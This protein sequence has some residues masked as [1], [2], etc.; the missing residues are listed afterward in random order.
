M[1]PR[2][3]ERWTQEIAKHVDK[4]SKEV[5]GLSQ[6]RASVEYEKQVQVALELMARLHSNSVSYANLILV[7]GYAGF[8]A[9]WSTLENNLP[10]WLH[11]LSGLLIV[12][13]LLFFLT[14]EVVK[15]IWSA[16][17]LRRIEHQMTQ[18]PPGADTMTQ[19]QQALNAYDRRVGRLWVWFLL[20]TIVFGLGGGLALLVGFGWN[21]WS[22]II[23][24]KP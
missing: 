2:Q 9:F 11:A 13:S 12:L 3:H 15:M 19:F 7:A 14:W 10:K 23:Q 5:D 18:R 4:L 20:P 17:T 8:F 16:F 21:L 22:A 1:D 24:H 6:F